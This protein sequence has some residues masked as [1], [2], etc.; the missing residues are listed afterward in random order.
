MCAK[1]YL[2]SMSF[3]PPF[4]CQARTMKAQVFPT[5]P[6]P[7]PTN[8]FFSLL[9]YVPYLHSLRA[10]LLIFVNDQAD[11]FP[12]SPLDHYSIYSITT[13]LPLPHH[14][15]PPSPS[16]RD[17]LITLNAL[18]RMTRNHCLISTSL[19]HTTA[20]PFNQQQRPVTTTP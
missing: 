12:R 19:L 8:I 16:H 7:L 11:P 3:L 13:A 4:N 17:P 14:L 9:H 2:T 18:I 15:L 20:N 1:Q 6:C 10:L 5:V